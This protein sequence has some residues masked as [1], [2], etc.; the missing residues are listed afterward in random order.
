MCD[1]IQTENNGYRHNRCCMTLPIA[2]LCTLGAAPASS[3][4]ISGVLA[5]HA[6]IRGPPANSPFS[7]FVAS[8]LLRSLHQASI[9]NDT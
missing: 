3:T 7:A 4:D 6:T 9:S 8:S 1:F 2:G 5:G